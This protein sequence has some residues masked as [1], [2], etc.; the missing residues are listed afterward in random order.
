M[1]KHKTVVTAISKISERA[2][3]QT[4]ALVVIHGQDLGRKF[5]LSG[6][7]VVIGR[8][9]KSDLRLDQDS[10]SRSHARIALEGGAATVSDLGST[11]GT[12]VNDEPV[13]GARPLRNGDFIKIGRTIFKYLE[14]GN[15]EGLYHEE[16]YKLTTTDGLTQVYNKRYLL[17]TLEREI[18]RCHRYARELSLVMLDIDRFKRINDTFGHL[19]GDSVLRQVAQVIKARIRREDVLARYGGEE[20]AL[21]LPEI[22]AAGAAITAE[23]ARKLVERQRFTFEGTSMPVTISCGV[24]A[25]KG[26]GIASAELIKRADEK[27]YEAKESGR[28]RVRS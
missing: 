22:D 5:D 8:A 16:I 11:N 7:A 26:E 28:N 3:A 15:I 13:Q 6:A 19:A 1:A 10:V 20:F 14:G 27:L 23:K 25:M 4:A 12:F 18:S 9:S 2:A 24:A 21:V 17:E